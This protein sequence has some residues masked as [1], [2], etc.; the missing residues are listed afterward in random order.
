MLSVKIIPYVHKLTNDTALLWF[1][2][3]CTCKQEKFDGG[4]SYVD[5]K[6]FFKTQ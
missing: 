6:E 1:T 5:I 2:V 4:T 3:D